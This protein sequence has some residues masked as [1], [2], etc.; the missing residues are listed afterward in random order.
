MDIENVARCFPLPL[1]EVVPHHLGRCSLS[2]KG[3]PQ[4][5]R[6]EMCATGGLNYKASPQP[7]PKEGETAPPQPSPKGREHLPFGQ[8]GIW[9]CQLV[10][11]QTSPPSGGLGGLNS[12]INNK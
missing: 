9:H 5:H 2:A 10:R 1:R 12:Q 6:R 11:T 4:Q 7:P 8:L 3:D